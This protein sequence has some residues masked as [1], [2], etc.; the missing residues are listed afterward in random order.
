MARIM[1]LKK[2]WIMIVI[3][4]GLGFISQGILD[5]FGIE[6]RFWNRI[7]RSKCLFLIV[8]WSL[9]LLN[10]ACVMLASVFPCWWV[11]VVCGIWLGTVG[12][13]VPSYTIKR[14]GFSYKSLYDVYV[15]EAYL[16]E[17]RIK[18]RKKMRKKRK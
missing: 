2:N 11:S 9:L 15:T 5:D 12:G 16:W 8:F 1:A 10:C 17:R 13:L 14:K 6:Y 7:L 4:L 18:N 3:A